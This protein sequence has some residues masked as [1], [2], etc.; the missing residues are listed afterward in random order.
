MFYLIQKSSEERYPAFIEA[1][2]KLG[3]EYEICKYRPFIHEIDFKTERKDVFCFG[4]YELTDI[5]EKYG[6]IPGQI[7]S[8]NHNFEIYGHK[9]GLANMLNGDSIIMEFT[10]EL[11]CGEQWEEFFARPTADKKIFTGQIFTRKSWN[12][13]VQGCVNN[14]TTKYITDETKIMISSIKEIKQEIRCWVVGGR[15]VTISQYKFGSR[16]VSKNVDDD[17]EAK[18]FAQ[19]MVDRYNPSEAFVLDICRTNVGFKIIEIN[20]INASGFYHMDCE[21]LLLALEKEFSQEQYTI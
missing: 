16:V 19:K 8:K 1:M 18:D 20:C 3:I 11:P 15:V 12:E 6:F 2:E 9:F 4:A 13:Y 21:K 14:D 17:F 5:S 7:S 10:D